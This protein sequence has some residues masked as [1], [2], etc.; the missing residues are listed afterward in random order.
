MVLVVDAMKP[1]RFV[2]V[3]GWIFFV[4][5]SLA[6]AVTAF[7]AAVAFSGFESMHAD[8]RSQTVAVALLVL[9]TCTLF[10][11][12]GLLRRSNWARPAFIVL[13]TLGLLAHPFTLRMHWFIRVLDTADPV[14]F[15]WL[16]VKL[17][18]EAVRN[19]FR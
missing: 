9:S 1:G 3:L 18:S 17:S 19:E 15:V 10:V 5:S 13:L 6:I 8:R 11:S 12:V 4:V 2:T 14:L 16:I 7:Q